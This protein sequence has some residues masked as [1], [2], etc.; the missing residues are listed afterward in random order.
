MWR[1]TIIQPN[2]SLGWWRLTLIL[3]VFVQLSN[4]VDRYINNFQI[5]D[6]LSDRGSLIIHLFKVKPCRQQADLP[7]LHRGVCFTQT[8]LWIKLLGTV[9]HTLAPSHWIILPLSSSQV[10]HK[11]PEILIF[12]LQQNFKVGLLQPSSVTVYEYYNPGL[13]ARPEHHITALISL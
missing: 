13:R 5:V 3:C 9:G 10:S 12:R 6:N 8:T 11:V 7:I 4:S 2:K 1:R